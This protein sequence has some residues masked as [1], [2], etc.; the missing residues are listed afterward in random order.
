MYLP[1][2]FREDRLEVLHRF[3]EQHGFATL[4]T[5]S[6][7]GLTANHIP[8]ALDLEPAPLGTLRG[9]VSRAN[10][11]WRDSLPD[12]S[13][14]AIFQGPSAYITPSWYPSTRETGRMVPTYNYVV[15]HAHGPIRT[16]EDPAP[17]EQHLRTLTDLHEAAFP[18]PWKIEDAPADFFQAMMKGIVGIEIPIARLEGKW[19]VSQN[20]LPADRAGAEAG[21]RANGCPA[22]ADLVSRLK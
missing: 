12:V 2:H 15:V 14:L 6:A 7:D 17:L 10:P 16:F 4:V 21:L 22:M 19:K 11:L 3:I 20:R 9:H 5:L 8:M 1:T 18:A 13:A